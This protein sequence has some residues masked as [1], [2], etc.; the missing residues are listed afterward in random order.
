MDTELEKT[1]PDDIP[2]KLWEAYL[3]AFLTF[4]PSD[5]YRF[6]KSCERQIGQ[7][8]KRISR[9]KGQENHQILADMKDLHKKAAAVGFTVACRDRHLMKNYR[10]ALKKLARLDIDFLRQM[11]PG[12]NPLDIAGM[13]RTASLLRQK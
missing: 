5:K 7:L 8:E 2:E 3:Q 6:V 1:I 13:K 11:A 9:K 10:H 12:A 4:L